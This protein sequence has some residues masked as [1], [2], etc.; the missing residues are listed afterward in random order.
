MVR[1]PGAAHTPVSGPRLL[2]VED[3]Q[4]DADLIVALAGSQGLESEV[5]ASVAEA[6][7]ALRRELPFGVILDLRLPDGRGEQVLEALQAMSKKRV[8]ALVVTVEDDEG[9]ARLLGADDQV[10]KPI[11]SGRL[12]KW[13]RKLAHEVE[14]GNRA[15]PRH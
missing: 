13:F 8:P 9:P 11:D 6:L 7:S 1:L 5:V 3:D 2:V 10:P 12:S 14:A 4:R 15:D